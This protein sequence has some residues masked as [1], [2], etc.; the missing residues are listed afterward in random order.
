MYSCSVCKNVVLA[1]GEVE[2]GPVIEYWPRLVT[3]DATIPEPA[4]EYLKQAQESAPAGAVMLCASA[5][6]AM[7]K[8]KGLTEGNLSPRIKQAAKDH[9][10]TDDMAKWAHQVRLDANE[11]RHA[12]EKKPLPTPDDAKRSVAFAVAL[13]E[14]L[15]VLPSRVTRGIAE[16]KKITPKTGKLETGA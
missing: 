16:S 7:L 13:A 10:I 1:T 12:D 14:F 15:F 4:R 8:A 3:L 2:N 11:P 9:L 6:D 5:V